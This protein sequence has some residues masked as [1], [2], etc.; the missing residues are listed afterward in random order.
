VEP[1]T[2][3]MNRQN[4]FLSPTEELVQRNDSVIDEKLHSV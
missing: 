4:M 2:D 3:Y 1:E